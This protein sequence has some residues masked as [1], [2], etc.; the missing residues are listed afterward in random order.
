[1]KDYSMSRFEIL[2]EADF[3]C[4]LYLECITLLQEAGFEQ[5]F[6]IYAERSVFNS[7]RKIDLVLGNNEVL[8]EM[9]IEPNYQGVKKP[10]SFTLIKSAGKS[11]NSVEKDLKKI[12]YYATEGKWGH[13]IMIDEDGRHFRHPF[14]KNVNWEEVHIQGK[15][16]HYFHAFYE[17]YKL[18]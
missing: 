10:Y 11:G 9:K 2:S 8:V 13:F 12:Q 3:R 17:P 15:I 18:T 7:R 14:L 5:P 16:V 6:K 4:A 1:M